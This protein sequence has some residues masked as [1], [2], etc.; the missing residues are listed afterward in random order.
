MLAF[1]E[2][3]L[4]SKQ[5]HQLSLVARHPYQVG[6]LEKQ[7]S[8]IAQ[9]FVN[10]GVTVDLVTAAS[11]ASKH[12]HARINHYALACNPRGRYRALRALDRASSQWHRTHPRPIIFGIDR[13]THATH[14]RAG[15]G[16]HRAYLQREALRNPF[17][18]KW[19]ARCSLYGRALLDL[20]KTSLTHP[21]LRLIIANSNMV[22]QELTSFYPT[23]RAPIQ[24]IHNGVEWHELTPCFSSWE[25]KKKTLCRQ[26]NLDPS[27]YHFL[28]VGHGFRRKGL[29]H[30]LRAFALLKEHH[31]HLS[32]VGKD[33]HLARFQ[34]E[35]YHLGISRQVTFFGAQPD[36]T[37][38][39]AL[40]DC[41]V[42][43]SLYDPFANVTVEALAMGLYVVSS[44]FNG[45]AE[46]L[47]PTNGTLIA[48]LFDI[49]GFA[50]TLSA[51][52]KRPKTA[53]SALLIRN[54]VAHLDFSH[55]MKT[56]VEATFATASGS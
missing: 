23:L 13:I 2:T 40:S 5:P 21:A 1:L 44:P 46:I 48:D 34:A 29:S 35:S 55:Q 43:P 17:I 7:L 10:T 15:N 53:Q 32:I 47:T 30:L 24:V 42:I 38:F 9:A 28:F 14:L 12:M 33:R 41:L 39:Y 22:K 37:P 50:A 36:T 25:E 52:F 4:S 6:G 16:V 27:H 19:K 51:A 8:Y 56:L 11:H 3:P 26:W 49:E 20:E 31:C 18:G 45:G 54:K